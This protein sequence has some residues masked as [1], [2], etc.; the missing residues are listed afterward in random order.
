MKYASVI[1]GKDLSELAYADIEKYF[2][3]EREE[4]DQAEF[5]SYVANGSIDSKIS[6]LV[7]TV[8]ALLNSDGGILIWG[9]PIGEKEQRGDRKVTVFKGELTSLPQE[10][11]D[12][13]WIISKIVDKIVP[14]PA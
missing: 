1:L 6:G 7:R 3:V 2:H 12:K 14:L 4:S 8:A 5:K 10:F 9:A 11:S 13:D